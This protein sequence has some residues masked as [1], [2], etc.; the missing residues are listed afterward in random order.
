MKGFDGKFDGNISKDS[1]NSPISFM[2]DTTTF[3]PSARCAS[4]YRH[5]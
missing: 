5:S 1:R 4:K 2:N 3:A